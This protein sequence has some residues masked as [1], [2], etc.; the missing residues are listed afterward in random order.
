MRDICLPMGVAKHDL[1]RLESL[2]QN[3][4]VHHQNDVVIRQ[5]D[6]FHTLYA[7]KSGMY[8]SV[9]LSSEGEEYVVGFHLPGE[10]VGL[11]AIYPEAYTSSLIALTNSVLCQLDYEQLVSLSASIPALQHQ[12][13]R[14][15]SKEINVT[16]AFQGSQTAEQKLAAF[17]HNLAVR[18]EV[19]G[20]SG[21]EFIL[22]MTRQD[23]AN[24]LGMA[25]ET[26][27]R[28]LKQ[29]QNRKVLA[30]KHREMTILDPGGL[31]QLTGCTHN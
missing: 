17:I 11:D 3:S 10:I 16:Q 2:V 30:I 18:N 29:F 23:I 8:K 6:A 5:D 14:L 1:E 26:I 15:S 24:H 28:L 9:R 21:T 31:L 25:A 4:K 7:V 12:L 22:A 20:Y 19:R 13:L 27:S